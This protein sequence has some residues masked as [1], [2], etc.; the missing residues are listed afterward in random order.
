MNDLLILIPRA[1]D[2]CKFTAKVKIKLIPH[3]ASEPH[4]TVHK[5]C[6]SV[7]LEN[8]TVRCSFMP[9]VQLNRHMRAAVLGSYNFALPDLA[10]PVQ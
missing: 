4:C 1:G 5:Q 3:H 10:F 8:F 6:W 9:L 2:E 7:R